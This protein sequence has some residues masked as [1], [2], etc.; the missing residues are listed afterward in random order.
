[1][2]AWLRSPL[3]LAIYLFQKLIQT[4][5]HA[6]S[7]MIPVIAATTVAFFVVVIA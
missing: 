3:E 6:S 4:A 7:E 1:M 2:V 5:V